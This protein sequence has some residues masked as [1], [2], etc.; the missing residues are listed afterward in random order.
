M[1]ETAF[2][3]FDQAVID[4]AVRRIQDAAKYVTYVGWRTP[5][6]PVRLGMLRQQVEELR[7][8]LVVMTGVADELQQMH[9]RQAAGVKELA[10][11]VRS[12]PGSKSR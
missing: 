4:D 6:D 7:V 10:W 2:N 12:A 3:R 5:K 1:G 11:A 8:G 9:D